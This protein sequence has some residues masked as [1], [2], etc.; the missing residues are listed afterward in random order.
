[1]RTRASTTMT[2]GNGLIIV[3]ILA[4]EISI[5]TISRAF[6]CRIASSMRCHQ[7]TIIIKSD[8][9]DGSLCLSNGCN[10]ISQTGRDNLSSRPTVSVTDN[11][12]R[13]NYFEHAVLEFRHWPTILFQHFHCVFFFLAF[14]VRSFLSW[15]V[16]CACVE[17][18]DSKRVARV[19]V[20]NRK[21]LFRKLISIFNDSPRLGKR[22]NLVSI[23]ISLP[24]RYRIA[25]VECRNHLAVQCELLALVNLILTFDLPAFA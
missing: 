11:N 16:Q 22:L 23:R 2:N 21:T 12:G 13:D 4:F 8:S 24:S 1:M 14:V 18:P 10:S 25:V 3:S 15:F 20:C 5:H 7:M 9:V 6:C 19:G 17:S